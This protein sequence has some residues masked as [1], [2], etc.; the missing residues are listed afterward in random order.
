LRNHCPILS[1]LSLGIMQVQGISDRPDRPKAWYL[2]D[3]GFACFS[4]NHLNVLTYEA[5]TFEGLDTEK[6]NQMISHAQNA[7]ADQDSAKAALSRKEITR[8]HMIV[9]MAEM[10]SLLATGA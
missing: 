2:L 10:A 5:I 9:R 4:Q 7:L 8:N 3:G 1:N 6:V